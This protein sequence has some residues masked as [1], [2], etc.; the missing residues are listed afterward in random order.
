M[1]KLVLAAVLTIAATGAQAQNHGTGSTPNS[2][3]VQ[4]HA[5]SSG[6]HVQL[7]QQTNPNGTQRN[8]HSA[9]GNVNPHTGAVGTQN[10]RH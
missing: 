7:N 2:R 6:S 9:T 8:N 1:K 10:P 3:S 5:T 4:G